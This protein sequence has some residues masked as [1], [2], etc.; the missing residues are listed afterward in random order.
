MPKTLLIDGVRFNL[1]VPE[2]EEKQF[3]PIIK[4]HSKEIFGN[5]AIYLDIPLRIKSEAGLGAEPDGFAIDPIRMELYVVEVE[6]SKHDPYKHINDQLTRFINSLDNTST[7]NSVVETLF[8]GINDNKNYKDYFEEKIKENLHRWLTK[9][10]SRPPIIVVI[11]EEKTPQVLEACKILMKSYDTR[12]LEFQTYQREGAPSVHAH[13]FEPLHLGDT[14][15]RKGGEVGKPVL[16][17]YQSW[18]KK[19]AWV[20]ANVREVVEDLTH[21]INALSNVVQRPSGTDYC[22]YR[23]KPSSKS[24][25]AVF[26]L[27]QKL[28]KVRIRADPKTLRDNQKWVKDKVFNWFIK[29]GQE[30]EFEVKG[31]EQ[32][33]YAMELIQQSY[34]ISGEPEK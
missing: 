28:L 19:L 26:M 8:D 5:D 17:H 2:N 21:N 3:H 30:R 1:W 10:L 20:D 22:F 25:F 14:E 33:A 9:L 27:T 31:R 12:I 23:E 34:K 16:E 11:I 24:V 7:K 29:Q 13:L 4:E 18:E 32:A 15:N 6:L